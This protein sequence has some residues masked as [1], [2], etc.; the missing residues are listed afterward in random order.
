MCI[1]RALVNDPKYIFADEPC[2][3]L[4]SENTKIVMDMLLNL[5]TNGKTIIMV[6]HDNKEAE[7]ASRIITLKDGFLIND[8]NINLNISKDNN[9]EDDNEKIVN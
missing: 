5:N 2:G 4:D 3:N 9:L 1:A 8:L 6:T 7:Y